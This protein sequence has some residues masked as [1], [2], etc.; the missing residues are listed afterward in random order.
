MFLS[1]LLT[2]PLETLEFTLLHNE[3]SALASLSQSCRS[4]NYFIYHTPNDHFWKLYFLQY[5]DDPTE[6]S[7]DVS[8]IGFWRTEFCYRWSI[9][10]LLGYYHEDPKQDLC[11]ITTI[12]HHLLD[13]ATPIHQSI[14]PSKNVEFL[15]SCIEDAWFFL[16]L[17]KWPLVNFQPTFEFNDCCQYLLFLFGRYRWA[18]KYDHKHMDR[19]TFNDSTHMIFKFFEYPCL[20]SPGSHN[21]DH[22]RHARALTQRFVET[23]D[24]VLEGGYRMDEMDALRNFYVRPTNALHED[25][26]GVCGRWKWVLLLCKFSS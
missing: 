10:G 24:T 5:F 18:P 26:F 13:K 3:P 15:E 19:I 7:H 17:G 2:L 21:W 6:Q 16:W 9:K 1:K 12:F 22:L 20:S 14:E 8:S 4:L 25:R 11:T 23:E